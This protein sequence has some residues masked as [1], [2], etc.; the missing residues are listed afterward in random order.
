LFEKGKFVDDCHPLEIEGKEGKESLFI[1]S[2]PPDLKI[3]HKGF[4][5]IIFEKFPSFDLANC[6]SYINVND[7][8]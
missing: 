3:T 8:D 1:E 4:D 2:R 6:C 7:V 5:G